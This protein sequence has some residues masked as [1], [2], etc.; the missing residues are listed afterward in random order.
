[1]TYPQDMPDYAG[2]SDWPEP[3]DDEDDLELFE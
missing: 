1:V 3:E 2:P